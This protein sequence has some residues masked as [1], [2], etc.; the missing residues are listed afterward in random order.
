MESLAEATGIPVSAL[1][2]GG[3]LFAGYPLALAHRYLFWGKSESV[4]NLF[5]AA[6]GMGLVG[7]SFGKDLIHSV[8]CTF[9]Q[10]TI[11]Q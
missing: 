8:I 4:Q 11:L 2:L 1:K 9:A 7:L 10:W 6:T 3:S 5:F